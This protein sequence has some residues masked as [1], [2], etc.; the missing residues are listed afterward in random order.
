MDR[1]KLILY[2]HVFQRLQKATKLSTNQWI[3]NIDPN[4][5]EENEILQEK[6]V[7]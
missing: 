4:N 5:K 1:Q 2:I 3:L 7:R 6:N